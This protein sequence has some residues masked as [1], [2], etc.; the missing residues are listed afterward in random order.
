M[1]TLAMHS[2]LKRVL[3]VYETTG[4]CYSLQR[5]TSSLIDIAYANAVPHVSGQLR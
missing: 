5:A 1:S 3:I 2:S 4:V